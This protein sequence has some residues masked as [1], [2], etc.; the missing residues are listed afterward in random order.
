M[1][2]HNNFGIQTYA[3]S[4]NDLSFRKNADCIVLW[5]RFCFGQTQDHNKAK[6]SALAR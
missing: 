3:K 5:D 1:T 2:I 6:R 4:N